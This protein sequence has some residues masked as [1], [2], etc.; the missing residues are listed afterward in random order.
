M[1]K[2]SKYVYFLFTLLIFSSLFLLV[3]ISSAQIP[4]TK[5]P[6][7]NVADPEFHSLRPYQANSR[8]QT[9]TA[10]YA[11]FCG[12]TLTLEETI[13]KTFDPN[14]PNC[15]RNG[16]KVTCSYTEYVPPHLI[17]IDLSE[18]ELPIMGNT[19]EV[20]NSQSS[21]ETLDDVTKVNEYVSWYLNGVNNRAE[22]PFLNE[23]DPTVNDKVVNY[24][25]PINK[26][27]PQEVQQ[28]YR[29]QTVKNAAK[30]QHNQVV[31]C[32]YGINILGKEIG[33]IPGPCYDE[34]LASLVIQKHRLDEW[35]NH[36][37]PVR[38]DYKDNISYQKA[39]EKWRGKF[40]FKVP[41]PSLIPIIGGKDL[42]L[43]GENP[44]S[45]NYYSSL[46]SYIPLSSTEDIEGNIKVDSLSSVTGSGV[47][48]IKFSNQ[49]PAELFFSH[50][51]EA[52]QL[53]S[54]LQN[55]YISSDQ[56]G[57]KT[58]ADTAVEPPTSCTTIDVRSNKGDSLFATSI[59]GNLEYTVSFTC[60]FDPPTCI[61][62]PSTRYTP[63]CTEELQG[64][65]VPPSWSCDLKFN[66]QDCP[67]GYVCG[68]GCSCEEPTQKCQKNIYIALSTTSNTPK[69]DDVWS[70][71][72]AGPTAVVKRMFPKLGD[73]IGTLKDLPGSTDI[74]YTGAES[75]S[76]TLNLPH[77]GGISEYFLKGI[78][79]LLR[80]KGYGE[81]ISFGETA[82][83]PTEGANCD[84]TAPDI[85]IPG[86]LTKEQTHTLALNW[87]SGKPGNQVMECYN[88]T[89]KRSGAAGVNVGLTIAL[90]LHES[91]A[92][93]YSLG[94]MQDFG[95]YWP[96]T[97]PGYTT[98]INEY[99]R[100][101][102]N[103][104]YTKNGPICLGRS[105]IID[106]FMAWAVVYKSGKCD[107]TEPGAAQFYNEIKKT[108][109]LVAPSCDIP[110]TTTDTSCP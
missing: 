88:D 73:Q 77:V 86:L 33:G 21:E 13:T 74:S 48:G 8:C 67:T 56:M 50:I 54:I 39:Y 12:N 23:D 5:I 83:S 4:P 27:L 37:P 3:K 63:Q 58:G 45:P 65:C 109:Q 51:Q 80:P 18:A 69:I 43:C 98:Q 11:S 104:L 90:W 24:S 44:L 70:R 91:N 29:A 105:D 60:D 101:A 14:D 31:G 32:T 20:I 108:F 30:T 89:V 68:Q 10:S 62:N 55:T 17:T 82:T 16:D 75:S 84:Q 102:K 103:S 79:T 25:G 94:Y 6:C 7:N 87:V 34:G 35:S 78:Q 71:L 19:E 81:P 59:T 97:F 9:E 92:S 1:K 76:A 99:F 96:S 72:V 2:L 52:D 93:N 41:I 110:T 40:C 38:S 28:Q 64:K 66:Q 85:T 95:A 42:L 47:T 61:G 57:E 15:K 46:Y 49:S 36:L 107:P 100:R 26:L 53:G 106:D 22:Y